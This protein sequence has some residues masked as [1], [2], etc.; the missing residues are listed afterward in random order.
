M[1]KS[2][3]HFNGKTVQI[4]TKVQNLFYTIKVQKLLPLKE[5]EC[6]IISLYI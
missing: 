6:S 4:T 2:M 3:L 5:G 1:E